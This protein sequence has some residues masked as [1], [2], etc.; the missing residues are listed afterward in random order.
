MIAL[1]KF[2][3]KDFKQLIQW[4]D[5]PKLLIQFAG[6]NFNFPLNE[7]QL[8][9]HLK[10]PNRRHFVIYDSNRNEAIGHA[11]IQKIA[12]R[13]GLICRVLLGNPTDR[14][15][16]LGKMLINELCHYGFEKC[17]F[18][19]MELNVYEWNSSA[20]KC[21]ESVGFKV[22]ESQEHFVKYNNEQWRIVRM[23]LDKKNF[24]SYLNSF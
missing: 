20:I 9:Q 10:L 1:K 18:N 22:I 21:Y 3:S 24:N 2:T 4:V 11:E 16:G 12:T 8:E 15:K 23:H 17:H 19:S 6:P 7:E 5:S 13:I 14:G